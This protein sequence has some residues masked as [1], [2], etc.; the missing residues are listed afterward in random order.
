MKKFYAL[1]DLQINGYKA[2]I[3]STN[4]KDVL[5]RGANRA[6]EISQGDEEPCPK[7]LSSEEILDMYGYEVREV[8]E[9]DYETI[10]NSE[11][12]GLLTSVKL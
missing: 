2:G 12:Y 10:L 4:Y 3:A 7:G 8:T 5:E 9:R 6:F 1:F 11:E